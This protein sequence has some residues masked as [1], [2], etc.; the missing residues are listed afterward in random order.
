MKGLLDW[1]MTGLQK[2]WL[3]L[4]FLLILSIEAEVW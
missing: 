2:T 4:D 3:F 1:K